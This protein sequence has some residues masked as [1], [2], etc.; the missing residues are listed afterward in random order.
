MDTTPEP[1]FLDLR[2][3]LSLLEEAFETPGSREGEPRSPLHQI[4]ERA[5]GAARR[6]WLQRRRVLKALI[7]LLIVLATG[8]VPV[9]A[10]LETTSTEAVINARLVTLRAPIEGEIAPMAH[11]LF[12]G[13]EVEVGTI[14]LRIVN[15]RA[16]RGRLDDLRQLIDRLEREKDALVARQ[17]DLKT[18]Q[19]ELAQQSRAFQDG[20]TRQLEARTDELR[21]EIAAAAATREEA[22]QALGRMS[23]L[24]ETGTTTKAAL[25]KARRD[26][27]VA[28]QT[29][30]ALRHR[31]AGAEVE[32]NAIRDGV[33][34]G[35]SYND[36]PQSTQRADEVAQRLSEVTAEIGERAAR[37]T[38]L[39]AQVLTESK[40]YA[41]LASAELTAPVPASIWE[42]LTAP[43]ESVV[44][45][46]ELVRL[47]DC[48]GVVVTATVGETAYNRLSVGDPARFRFRGESADHEGRII[49]LTG[50]ATAPANLAIQPS[51]LA[52]EPYRVTVSLPRLVTS[53]R[54]EVGRTGRVTFA[55]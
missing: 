47:L 51:A 40:R 16:D 9:R 12:V 10:L 44:R 6:I 23:R 31:L 28:M 7:G 33:F 43:G 13:S 35:D 30:A 15:R 3:Q 22:E 27:T 20:R 37:L 49:G 42:V 29:H 46:Q 26:A 2:G 5:L 32:L 4:G 14:L 18:S 34:V 24:A 36:R 50:V 17:T 38:H 8:Y 54:C 21:S 11:R 48:S 19:V 1:S 25:D 41:E 55:K 53:G 52:K 45:G 39:K